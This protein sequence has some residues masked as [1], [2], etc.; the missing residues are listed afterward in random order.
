MFKLAHLSDWH[1]ASRPRFAELF[2][3]RGL[4]RINWH[5][6]RKH[7][8]RPEV[9]EAKVRDL[10]AA[11]PDHIAVTGDLVNLSLADEY[12]RARGW[13]QTL[14]SPTD[15]TLVPGNHDVY[16]RGVQQAPAQYWADY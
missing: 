6:S 9:F 3:K 13:L 14:G 15:V 8:H 16:V 1:L 4:G 12:N 11:P 7:V 5:R 2:S 10:K